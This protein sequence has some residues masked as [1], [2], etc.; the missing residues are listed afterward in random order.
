[1]RERR[2][3]RRAGVNILLN[4]FIDG[5]PHACRALDLSMGGVLVK[6]IHEPQAERD[7]FPLQLGLP[8]QDPIWIWSRAVWTQGSCQA[9]R[10][11]SM[12]AEDRARLAVYLG[13][14]K[15]AA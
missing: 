8:G 11:V 6:R 5:F 4:K 9:L 15:R 7:F 12:D 14:V 1:M 2:S 10:F 3:S 13:T